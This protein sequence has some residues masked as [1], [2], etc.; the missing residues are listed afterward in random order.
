MAVTGDQAFHHW[1]A[2]FAVGCG[3]TLLGVLLALVAD[4]C[5]R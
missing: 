3:A 5:R 1:L 2:G 4:R